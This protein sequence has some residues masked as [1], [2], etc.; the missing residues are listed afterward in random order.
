MHMN[1]FAIPPPTLQV[2]GA[3]PAQRRPA[4][5]ASDMDEEP[6]LGAFKRLL[7]TIRER[8][9]YGLRRLAEMEEVPSPRWRCVGCGHVKRFTRAV[10]RET[11]DRCPKCRG[12]EF[13]V[14]P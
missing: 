8:A 2:L 3:K 1:I 14:E 13:E 9:D 6:P 4:R 5:I 10:P 12:C 11:A 7:E